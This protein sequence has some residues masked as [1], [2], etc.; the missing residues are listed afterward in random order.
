MS[1]EV[2]LYFSV[3]IIFWQV[4]IQILNFPIYDKKNNSLPVIF[5]HSITF[6]FFY[7]AWLFMNQLCACLEFNKNNKIW[8]H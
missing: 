3:A 2:N 5:T 7:G 1:L 8:L 6:V 4:Y